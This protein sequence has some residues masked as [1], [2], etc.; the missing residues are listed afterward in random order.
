MIEFSIEPIEC[1]EKEFYDFINNYP[2][3]LYEHWINTETTHICSYIDFTVS[4]PREVAWFLDFYLDIPRKYRITNIADDR[5]CVV[6][7]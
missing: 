5:R 7:E 3:K 2:I 6:S 1:T 4:P